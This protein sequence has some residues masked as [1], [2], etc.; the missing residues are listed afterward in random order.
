MREDAPVDPVAAEDEEIFDDPEPLIGR[1]VTV[2]GGV[3][4]MITTAR[5][6]GSAFRIGGDSREPVAVLSATPLPQLEVDDTVR[7]SGTTVRIQRETFEEDFGVGAD[8]LFDDPDD[9]FEE[10]EGQAAAIA[11]DRMEI[12]QEQAGN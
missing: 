3:S 8:E 5:H 4:E 11:A 2:S 1:E 6:V 10:A 9:F 12:L 7:V